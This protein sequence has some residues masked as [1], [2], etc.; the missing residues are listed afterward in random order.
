MVRLVEASLLAG[1]LLAEELPRRWAHV[2]GVALRGADVGSSGRLFEVL[3]TAGILHDIG[4]APE[5][6]ETGFHPIDG[7][8]HLRRLG[9]NESIVNLVAHHTCAAVEAEV[10]GLGDILRDEFPFDPSLP[11]DELCFCDMTTSADGKP[12][13]IDDRIA[14]IR[15]RRA[16]DAPVMAFLDQAEADLRRVV[17]EVQAKIDQ[18]R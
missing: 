2:Q 14:G 12:T 8:R 16:D 17:A 11:H 9:C 1:E 4:Y 18:P 6:V 7:A 15:Q 10:R 13:T 5:L 3:P